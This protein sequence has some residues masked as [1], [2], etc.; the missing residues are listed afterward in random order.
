LFSLLWEKNIISRIYVE[1]A[2]N[3]LQV[4]IGNSSI[5]SHNEAIESLTIELEGIHCVI[6]VLWATNQPSHDM[7]IGN[8]F[9]RLYSTCT[10]TQTQL[11]FTI[12][13]HSVPINKLDKAYTR[14]K[15]EFT[16]SSRGEKIIPTQHEIAVSISLLE[17]SIKEQIIEQQ[18]ELCKELYSD[19]PL[20]FWVKDKTLGKFTLLNPNTIIRVKQTVYTHQDIQEFDK[21]IKELL[22]KGL[23]QNSKSPHT[24]PAFMV[25]NHAEEKRGK[26]RMVINYKNLTTILS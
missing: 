2:K 22:E 9:Q 4:R 10:Q 25:R 17:M 24:S 1:K 6:P 21:Q 13:G 8:N 23:I 15:I 3:P 19:N 14:Q 16:R 11:I 12:N 5:M 7:I 26:A 20:K 18:E